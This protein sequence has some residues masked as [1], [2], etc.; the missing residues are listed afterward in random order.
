MMIANATKPSIMGNPI[1][2]VVVTFRTYWS[3]IV[4][5][6]AAAAGCT[7]SKDAVCPVIPD[8][9]DGNIYVGTPDLY[10]CILSCWIKLK[11]P[12]IL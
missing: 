11:L 10:D 9:I 8:N 4:E 3:G 6:V 2:D 12:E 5:I 7:V 1:F